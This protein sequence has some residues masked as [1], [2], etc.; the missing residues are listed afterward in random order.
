MAKTEDVEEA[1]N[2]VAEAIDDCL[3]ANAAATRI[4]VP[5]VM[6]EWMSQSTWMLDACSICHGFVAA[7]C[8][9]AIVVVQLDGIWA[10]ATQQLLA[11]LEA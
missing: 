9:A 2:H 11:R 6:D 10:A 4:I 7:A 3:D 8:L 1:A 5:V